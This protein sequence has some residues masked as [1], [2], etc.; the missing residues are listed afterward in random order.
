MRRFL[1][2]VRLLLA[3]GALLVIAAAVLWLVPSNDYIFLPDR[4]RAVAPLVHVPG[5]KRQ[6]GPGGIY[7]VDVLVRRASLLEQLAPSIRNGSTLVPKSAFESPGENQSQREQSDLQAMSR[8]QDI[9]TA[10]A[11]RELGYR[12]RA[13]PIGVLIDAVI[14][15]TPAVSKL[16]PGDLITAVDGQRVR[17]QK[18]LQ[19]RL[20]GVRPGQTIVLRVQNG[21]S[22]RSETIRTMAEP[23]H[24]KRPFIGVVIEQAASI[25]LPV[26][27]TINTGDIGGPSAGLA[28]ALDVMEE[29]GRNVDRGYRVAAT[30]ELELSGA[31]IPVGGVKQKTIGARQSHVDVL[32]VPAG[33]NAATARQY[34]GGVKVFAVRSVQQALRRLAT[35]PQRG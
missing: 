22:V 18:E 29:L 32:L 19:H 1:T 12:V 35:L 24:R 15:G 9:G 20:S 26:H 6:R 23:R 34:A 3:G 21:K 25:D 17:S 11:L 33:E 4:A 31:V 8:S 14:P 16:R 2:P 27:V 7:L 28:F 10:V 30:G 13:R 5:S